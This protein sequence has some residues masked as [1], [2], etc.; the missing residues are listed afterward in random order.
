MSAGAQKGWETVGPEN[1]LPQDL[2]NL[3]NKFPLKFMFTLS[4]FCLTFNWKNAKTILLKIF[5]IMDFKN[6][7]QE[8]K[9]GTL[10]P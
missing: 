6:W 8:T 5:K 10:R 2:P 1:N 3:K 4:I 9:N 7:Q